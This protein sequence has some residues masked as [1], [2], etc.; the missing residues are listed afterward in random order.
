MGSPKGRRSL[1]NI[2]GLRFPHRVDGPFDL[3]EE[4][5][6][7]PSST[8]GG[9]QVFAVP[10]RVY[11]NLIVRTSVLDATRKI[12]GTYFG[13]RWKPM[14]DTFTSNAECEA[15]YDN[16]QN[17]SMLGFENALDAYSTPAMLKPKKLWDS[18][19]IARLNFHNDS[20]DMLMRNAG[21]CFTGSVSHP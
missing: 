18:E 13:Y 7:L 1:Q 12:F 14:S 6:E 4:M 20:N 16:F 17:F 9:T 11:D 10:E 21:S 5:V 19:V 3:T 15:D 8:V 2:D